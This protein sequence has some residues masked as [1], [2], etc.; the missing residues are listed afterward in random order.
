MALLTTT[1]Q[2]VTRGRLPMTLVFML[3]V[4]AMTVERISLKAG[5]WLLAV[6]TAIEAAS[7]WQWYV[8]EWHGQGDLRMDAAAQCMGW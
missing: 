2:Q 5:L 1:W 6:L 4:A 3:L 7:L 8:S